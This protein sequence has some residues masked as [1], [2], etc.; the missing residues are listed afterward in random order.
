MTRPFRHRKPCPHCGELVNT[1]D[2]FSSWVR[3]HP[4]L[5]SRQ[6]F[7][8]MDKDL[9]AHRVVRNNGREFECL[10]FIEVK[11]RGADLTPSQRATM[12]IVGMGFRNRNN[13]PT[14][15]RV[16]QVGHRCHEAYCPLKKRWVEVRYFGF[17][18]L[19]LSGTTPDD[20]GWIIWD[21]RPVTKTVLIDLLRFDRDPDTLNV[22]DWR[23]HHKKM[24]QAELPFS[25]SGSLIR[26]P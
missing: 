19:R 18:L 4:A 24:E 15:K 22:M 20:S 17:H 9:T 10:M 14:K 25:G 11:T 13:T 7:V 12:H 2:E 23:I 26:T 1:E 21:K 16:M 3:E 8:F 5:E 6:G